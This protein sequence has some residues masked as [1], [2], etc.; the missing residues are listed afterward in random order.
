MKI[1]N[2]LG[3]IVESA[4]KSEGLSHEINKKKRTKLWF[5]K[6]SKIAEIKLDDEIDEEIKKIEEQSRT[7]KKFFV[8][9][10][11]KKHGPQIQRKRNAVFIDPSQIHLLIQ[12][13]NQK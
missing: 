1:N 3:S 6:N 13:I 2:L 10:K 11:K 8:E 9:E 7:K 5:E 4:L 12:K